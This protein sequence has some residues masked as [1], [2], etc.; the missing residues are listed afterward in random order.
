LLQRNPEKRPTAKE[1]LQDD[2]ILTH[3][4]LTMSENLD[5]D[6]I[7]SIYACMKRFVES[8]VYKKSILLMIASRYPPEEILHLT[9]LFTQLDKSGEGVI[10][11]SDFQQFLSDFEDTDC[12]LKVLFN[13]IV[14]NG[15]PSIIYAFLN[16][17]SLTHFT[18]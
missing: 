2:F 11:F 10:Y 7:L 18:S 4:R 1:A 15:I 5:S 12:E 6:L 8:S 3:H 9:H 16:R 14:S 13:C 17:I